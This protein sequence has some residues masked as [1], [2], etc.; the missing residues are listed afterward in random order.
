MFPLN[1]QN[2]DCLVYMGSN[3]TYIYIYM[4][5]CFHISRSP[6]SKHTITNQLAV[7]LWAS[8]DRMDHVSACRQMEA[9]QWAVLS[10][11]A[12]D[13]GRQLTIRLRCYPADRWRTLTCNIRTGMNVHKS[14]TGG[15]AGIACLWGILTAL[16]VVWLPVQ[17]MLSA[18]HSWAEHFIICI[19]V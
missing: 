17:P 9:L 18:S 13:R 15:T 16:L 1:C 11:L 12:C 10:Y 5:I 3:H 19:Q 4:N 14:P 2:R 7:R 6:S 8:R